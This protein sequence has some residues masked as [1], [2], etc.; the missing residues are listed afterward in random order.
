MSTVPLVVVGAHLRGQPL[1][2]QLTALEGTFLRACNTAPL[3]RLYALEAGPLPKP[4]LLRVGPE[5]GRAFA[6]EV[7]SL[8]TAAF[9]SFILKVPS[10]LCI[11]TVQ[12]EDGSS[13]PGFLCE[14]VAIS[15]AKDISEHPGWVH[16]LGHR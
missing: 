3:Y 12:L 7:W 11:G 4:G 8:P 6:V 13:A 5:V 2:H 14:S 10:P 16:Y 15:G 9:G 1:N